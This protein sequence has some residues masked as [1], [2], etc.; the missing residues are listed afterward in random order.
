MLY[1]VTLDDIR[2][3]K[4]DNNIL[5]VNLKTGG[6]LTVKSFATANSVNDFALA[7]GTSWSYSGGTWTQKT[8]SEE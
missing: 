7:D 5:K 2:T 1:D 6:S 8:V 4:V 3:A